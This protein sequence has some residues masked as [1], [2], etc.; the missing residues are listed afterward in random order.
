M[1]D[2]RSAA[3]KA[4]GRLS[5]KYPDILNEYDYKLVVEELQNR[6]DSE[7]TIKCLTELAKQVKELVDEQDRLHQ[8]FVDEV[9][10]LQEK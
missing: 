10:K 4:L 6:Y 2:A 1:P 5:K 9:E 3:E 8:E 7:E